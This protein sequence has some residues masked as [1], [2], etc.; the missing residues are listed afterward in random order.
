MT[1]T[2]FFI[3]FLSLIVIILIIF[4]LTGVLKQTNYETSAPSTIQFSIPAPWYWLIKQDPTSLTYY[5]A[6]TVIVN[7]PEIQGIWNGQTYTFQ[8]NASEGLISGKGPNGEILD[9]SYFGINGKA[10]LVYSGQE[11]F[12]GTYTFLSSSSNVPSTGRYSMLIGCE[13]QP[14]DSNGVP[15]ACYKT[16][17]N[18]QENCYDDDQLLGIESIHVCAGQT[19]FGSPTGEL[20]RGQDGQLYPIN[21]TEIFF[22][23]C[24]NSAGANIDRC[25]AVLGFIVLGQYGINAR[26]VTGPLYNISGT[27]SITGTTPL[28]ADNCSLTNIYKGY[29]NQL[30]RITPATYE[31]GEFIYN[32][33]GLYVRIYSRSTGLCMGPSFKINEAGQILPDQPI[34][35]PVQLIPC[36]TISNSKGN[37]FWW[38]IL[39]QIV[40]PEPYEQDQ[41]GENIIM[42]SLPQLIFVS[43]PTIIPLYPNWAWLMENQDLLSL[44][45]IN[46]QTFCEKIIIR[47]LNAEPPDDRSYVFSYLNYIHASYLIKS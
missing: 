43:N 15:G 22:T 26:C 40:Q 45:Q 13:D 39:P 28:G 1:L 7:T 18:N 30:W 24:T 38:Y 19:T 4:A 37:V 2:A 42:A 31:A 9:P 10:K 23:N 44:Q 47:N 21:T 5:P 6:D 36:G 14:M 33:G 12:C 46:G 11:G 20:C 35:G 34:T 32:P 8:Y 25:D 16:T 29:P 27:G 41:N 17:L 3:L